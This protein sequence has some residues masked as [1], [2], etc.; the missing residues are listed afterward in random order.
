VQKTSS[1]TNISARS[2][3][4]PTVIFPSSS[5]P[6]P[7]HGPQVRPP[8]PRDRRV[9]F[10]FVLGGVAGADVAGVVRVV[11]RFNAIQRRVGGA[12][13]NNAVRVLVGSNCVAGDDRVFSSVFEH[14]FEGVVSQ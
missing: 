12:T 4:Q 10:L 11:S 5:S 3:L 8:L 2:E 7:V 14:G 6:V 9:V 1:Q 13:A